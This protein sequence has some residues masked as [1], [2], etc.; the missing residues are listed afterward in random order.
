MLWRV[1]WQRKRAGLTFWKGDGPDCP[2][3]RKVMVRVCSLLGIQETHGWGCIPDCAGR[4]YDADRHI[5]PR[6]TLETI[7]L[8]LNH[9]SPSI[10]SGTTWQPGNCTEITTWA[11]CWSELSGALWRCQCWLT[12]LW[13]KQSDTFMHTDLFTALLWGTTRLSSTETWC[14][15]NKS[16]FLHTTLTQQHRATCT[17]LNKDQFHLIRC[18]SAMSFPEFQT[19]CRKIPLQK[20]KGEIAY[21]F[22]NISFLSYL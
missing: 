11:K 12:S 22:W 20:L 7:T 9:C 5:D 19:L 15:Q 18:F 16:L 3:C 10:S 8:V 4:H 13:E 1:S 17:T 21:A 14:L 2:V 6:W